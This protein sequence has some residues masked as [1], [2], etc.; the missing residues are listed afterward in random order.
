MKKITYLLIFLSFYGCKKDENIITD[1]QVKA[2][3]YQFFETLSVDNPDKTKL[4]DL[5]TD[6]YYIFENE[7]RYTMD[8]FIEFVNSFD[9]IESEWDL[10]DFV[11][12]TDSESAHATLT[13]IGRFLVKTDSGNI[14][15]N[16]EWL[17]SAY[18]IKQNDDLK[19][20]FYFSDAVKESIELQ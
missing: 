3:F 11:I 2:K 9:M 6:D 18:L 17:E 14:V 4:Y 1:D 5:V 16:F 13:N 7:R 8:E 20:K 10:R 19:F 15:M 12:D